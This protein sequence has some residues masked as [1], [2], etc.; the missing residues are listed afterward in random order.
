MRVTVYSNQGYKIGEVD[1][2]MQFSEPIR[3]DLIKRAALSVISKERQQYGTDPDAGK[4]QGKAWP[5]ARRRFGGTYGKG[6][7]R[8]ARKAL[9]HR[10]GQ[11]G[12]VGARGAQ[13]LKGLTAFPPK[14][15]RIFAEKINKR[16]NRKAIRSAISASAF[17]ELVR[18]RHKINDVKI[19]PIVVEGSTEAMKKSKDVFLLL[20]KLGLKEE[21][22][23]TSERKIRAGRGKMRGRK[24]KRKVGPLIIVSK[25]CDLEKAARNIAGVDVIQVKALNASVLAPG[26]SPGRLAVWTKPAIEMMQKERLFE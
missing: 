1:L 19:L 25:A 20:V 24:Y 23:R 7:S 11:F 13:T 10:G 15:E 21:L 9:W 26:A 5:K 4:R 12:W 8:V 16:E 17:I 2:P 3:T 22:S 18:M 6:I 14:S